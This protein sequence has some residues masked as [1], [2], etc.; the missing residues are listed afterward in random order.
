M[1]SL[2]ELIRELQPRDRVLVRA[3]LNVPLEGGRVADATRID[4]L[5]P[6]LERLLE[7][8]ARVIVCSHLGRPKS[9]DPAFSLAPVASALDER[10]PCPVALFSTMPPDDGIRQQ[11]E[12][13]G[14]GAVAL[15]EN[16]RYAAGEKKNDPDFA[17]VLAELADHFVNDAFGT[18][19]RAHASVVGVPQRLPAYAG[20]LVERELAVL[21]ELRDEPKRPFWVILGGAK[22][23]DKLGVVRHLKERVDGFLVGGG[24]ASTFLA[25]QGVPVGASRVE[26]EWLDE[27]RE[28]VGDGSSGGVEWRFPSDFIAGDAARAPSTTRVVE[29]GE[30]PGSLSFF[31]IG[32]RTREQF[33]DELGSARAIFWNGPLGVFEEEAFAEGTRSIAQALAALDVDR[34]IGGGDT[35]AAVRRFGVAGNMTHISTGGGASLEYL[36]GKALPGI[37]ALEDASACD[38]PRHRR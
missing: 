17:A 19:H 27:L 9:A 36:Q 13:L 37:Q 2:S 7:A 11:V 25:G 31:D 22:V 4:A 35:A 38:L 26:Q 21:R 23:T 24:M 14:P 16:L 34:I 18:C 28:V 5:L 10:L 29:R 8:R 33:A 3:D 6:T 30:D 32:P 1:R 15:L 20:L 12:A